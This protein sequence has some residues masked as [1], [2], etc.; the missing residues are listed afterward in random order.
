MKNL[1][2]A[3]EGVWEFFTEDSSLMCFCPDNQICQKVCDCDSDDF[4]VAVNENNVIYVMTQKKGNF[5]V[6]AY[7]GTWNRECV[8]ESANDEIYNKKITLI[9]N[10][11][12]LCGFYVLKHDEKFL[13]VHQIFG[14]RT[15]PEVICESDREINF[16]VVKDLNRNIY[17]AY[18]F[19]KAIYTAVY[20]WKNKKWMQK[21]NIMHMDEEVTDISISLDE[22]YKKHI[23]C[24]TK[25]GDTY[26]I[27]VDGEVVASSL[28][29]QPVCCFVKKKENIFCVFEYYG[30][31]LGSEFKNGKW[32]KVRYLYCEGFDKYEPVKISGQ[33][34]F[35]ING[36]N[37]IYS[38]ASKLNN[39]EYKLLF[40]EKN[41]YS[42]YC[43][44]LRNTENDNN[45]ETFSGTVKNETKS[46]SE[47]IK[48]LKRAVE[49]DETPKILMEIAN[50]LSDVENVLSK[51]VDIVTQINQKTECKKSS[52]PQKG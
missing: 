45:A 41:D 6:S 34:D 42:D 7:N 17:I 19:Q 35:D 3:L 49:K 39:G 36:S 32:E 15:T 27:T 44:K 46:I 12:W 20:V 33:K 26:K 13:L 1:V 21:E 38:Y 14:S 23:A 5:Y 30:K 29:K 18:S 50:R 25:N 31:L 16:S 51:V 8:L 22:E 11:N 37:F 43:R 2:F 52:E 40:S 28:L 24:C 10:N 4:D 9:S 47:E 48:S